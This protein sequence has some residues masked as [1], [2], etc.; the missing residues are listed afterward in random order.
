MTDTNTSTARAIGVIGLGAMGKGMAGS[1]R[2]AGFN[3]HVYDVR[4]EP[5]MPLPMAPRP[6][7][8]TARAVEVLVSVT[9]SSSEL[10]MADEVRSARPSL[11]RR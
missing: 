4:S 3:V 10:K 8:P 2:R 11:G 9:S 7:R 6:I 5:A 1:L